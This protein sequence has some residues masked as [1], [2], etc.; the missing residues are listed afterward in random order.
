MG[1]LKL[2][3]KDGGQ[4]NR[5]E[6]GLPFLGFVIYPDRIRMGRQAR[7]RLGRKVSSLHKGRRQGEMSERELEQRGM[8]LFAHAMHADDAAWRRAL[9]ARHELD[10]LEY[11]LRG[12]E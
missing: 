12:D 9:L 10:L 11:D 3:L 1:E 4:W 6:R 8:A 2:E 7:K 5:C